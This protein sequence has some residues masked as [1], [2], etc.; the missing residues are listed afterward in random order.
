VRLYA[1][2]AP[3]FHLLTAPADYA[4]EADRYRELIVEA[5]P[6]ATTLLELGSG[7]GNNA[8]HLKQRFTCTLSDL[9]PQMLTLS[10]EL[11]P[12]CEHVLGDMRTLRLGRSFDAVFV[13]DAVMYLTTEDDLRA[14][15]ETAFAHTRPGGVALFV[16]DCTRETFEPGT[17][18]GGHDGE[19]GRALRHLEWTHAPDSPGATSFATDHVVVLIE[20]G[21]E[22]RVVHDRHL[23]GL[24]PEHTWLHL[25]EGAGFTARVVPGDPTNEEAPQPAFLARRPG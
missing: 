9:S 15:M 22:P 25:L 21:A 19:D 10:R 16:P 23:Y 3:W 24:F 1:D 5:V 14:C 18:H 2:L 20:P 4:V 12:E 11:N 13:H 8:S 6:D 7:G 17:D